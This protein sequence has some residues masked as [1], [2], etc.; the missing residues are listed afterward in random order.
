MLVTSAEFLENSYS[1][2]GGI[3]GVYSSIGEQNS[4]EL[5]LVQVK[6]SRVPAVHPHPEIPKVPPGSS[7]L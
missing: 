1:R 7:P 2:I 4:A 3:R 6:G 5:A